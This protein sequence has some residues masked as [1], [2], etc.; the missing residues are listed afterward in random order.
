[1]NI[2][3]LFFLLFVH[4]TLLVPG[5]VVVKK[6][7]LLSKSPGIELCFGYLVSI[8][9]FAL[10]ATA[11]YAFGLSPGLS[12]LACWLFIVV[13]FIEL[14][15]AQYYKSLIKLR[16]P[17]ICLLLMSLFSSVFISLSFN[18][19]YSF[20][21]DPSPLPNRNYNV[22]STKVLNVAQT[23]ANDNYIPYRQAQFFINR[24]DPAKD[25]FIGEWGV[26]FFQRTPLLGAVT[27]NYFSLLGE[28]VP[29][30][31][32]W[33]V[34]GADPDKTYAQFQVI[35]AVLNALFI[36][37]AFFLLVKLFNRKT[38]VIT[39]LFLI[40][41]QFF[42]YNAVFS[43][44]KSLV[45]FFIIL[46]WLLILENRLRYTLLAGIAS[47]IAYL[48]H[49]LAVLY[50]GAS[51]L[52][53]LWNKRF[54]E[55]ILFG[56]TSVAF[57]VPWVLVSNLI[58]HKQSSFILYPISTVDIPQPEQKSQVIRQFLHTS[59]LHF[60]SIK[61]QNL[62]YLLSP[63]QLFTSEGG[64]AGFRRLWALG[65]FSI[66][67]SLG[68]GLMVPAGLGILKRLQG[69]SFW[70]L[71]LTPVILSTIVIGWPK[72]L[73][74]L[75]FAEATVVLLSGLAV[76]CLLKLKSRWW[77]FAAFLANC[78]QLMFFVTY[79]F[80]FAVAGWFTSPADIACL[81]VMAAIVGGTGYAIYL[82]NRQRRAWLIR[83][84][85]V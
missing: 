83:Y 30:D 43:W 34:N 62:L 64:Q 14:V 73:G 71:A 13:G 70:V 16:F 35:A 41:S 81:A 56:I 78:V 15:R 1:M 52:L 10:L 22:L 50:I 18:A 58:Y 79:S 74:S 53:L 17:I 12:R 37:P 85:G 65:I 69:S 25:S 60:L 5:Y 2:D 27:A 40:P 55:T 72:G 38:A 3:Y 29:V 26:T 36:V 9:V 23:P 61:I 6:T 59:P 19:K 8:V 46:S 49:D 77:L 32:T 67:G 11:D 47:G 39:C 28:K 24:S 4:L 57:A 82:F 75:H 45:A 44:P 54:R 80:K 76:A 63:Y 48:A 21:P 7:G 51:V 42:L 31:Y 68:I 66:P 33:S 20:I 84:L